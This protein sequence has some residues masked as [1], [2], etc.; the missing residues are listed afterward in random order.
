MLPL[1]KKII[2]IDMK[3]CVQL[4][5]QVSSTGE[6]NIRS[7]EWKAGMAAGSLDRLMLGNSIKQAEKQESKTDIH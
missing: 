4:K 1:Q 7:L 6:L 5:S 2:Q 3:K